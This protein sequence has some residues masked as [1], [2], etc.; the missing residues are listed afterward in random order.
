MKGP[1]FFLFGLIIPI[2]LFA[3]DDA[4]LKPITVIGTV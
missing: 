1:S 2:L 4:K 3:Y